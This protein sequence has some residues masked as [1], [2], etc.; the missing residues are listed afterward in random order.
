MWRVITVS[1]LAASAAV[2]TASPS[3]AHVSELSG[4]AYAYLGAG[5]T[6]QYL[7]WDKSTR[8]IRLSV[9]ADADMS[10]DRC[11]DATYDWEPDDGHY[12]QR[13]VRNCDPGSM[14]ETDPGGDGFWREPENWDSDTYDSP[15][16]G[17]NRAYVLVI[18][19][20]DINYKYAKKQIFPE[21]GYVAPYG[22]NGLAPTVNQHKAAVR[23]RYDDGQVKTNRGDELPERCWDKPEY[24]SNDC[25]GPG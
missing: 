18:D 14:V 15:I 8:K 2:C 3:S 22:G 9:Y 4:E 17:T 7:D 19:D 12:D 25:S 13:L 23:V 10:G 24:G 5:S 11:I 21:E 20:D 16:V 1:A 6:V